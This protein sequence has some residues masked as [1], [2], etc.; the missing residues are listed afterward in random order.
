MKYLPLLNAS[1]NLTCTVLLLIGL[2]LILKKKRQQHKILMWTTFGLSVAFLISYLIYHFVAGDVHFIG[3]GIIRPI[4]FFILISHI[5]LATAIVPLV[6]I[7]LTRAVKGKYARHRKIAR[8]TWPIW[9]YVTIT[10]VIVYL[11]LAASG[12][13]RAAG[14]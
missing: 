9:F 14:M 13:Y 12:S 8:W 10:G 1:I 3:T 2:V 5:L 4:Y 6:L 7:T 11:M